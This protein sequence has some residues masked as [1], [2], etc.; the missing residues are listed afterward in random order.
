MKLDKKN[1]SANIEVTFSPNLNEEDLFPIEIAFEG[2]R[3]WFD[4]KVAGVSEEGRNVGWEVEWRMNSD[5]YRI[6]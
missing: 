6:S 5:N 4:V 2:K 3:C 1:L